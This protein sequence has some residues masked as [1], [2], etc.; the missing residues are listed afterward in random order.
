MSINTEQK[1]Y[2]SYVRTLYGSFQDVENTDEDICEMKTSSEMP[3]TNI[4]ETDKCYEIQIA[5]PG[6]HRDDFIVRMN[7]DIL[8][9]EANPG[10][11]I[12]SV[13]RIL[14]E[15]FV[16]QGFKCNML[17]PEDIRKEKMRSGYKHGILSIL[18]PK[19]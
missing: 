7:E 4:I 19:M 13:K 17:M 3:P 6:F 18:V 8:M 11:H 1:N 10:T 9:V 2:R 15:Q 5:A 16:V 14:R 12:D